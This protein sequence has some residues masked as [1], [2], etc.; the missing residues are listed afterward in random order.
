MDAK[1]DEEEADEE[2][3]NEKKVHRIFPWHVAGFT[4]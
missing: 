1:Q 4:P 3:K 2:E